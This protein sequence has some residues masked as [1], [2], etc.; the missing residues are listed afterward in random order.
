MKKTLL[1]A[2]LIATAGAFAV[3]AATGQDAGT[4][5]AATLAPMPMSDV[6]AKLAAQGYEVIEIERDGAF[7]EVEMRDAKGFEVEAY[8]DVVTGETA[9]YGDDDD[10]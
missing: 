2:A 5:P 6:I 4:A 7:Y 3:G 10:A 1:T 9:P 8:L